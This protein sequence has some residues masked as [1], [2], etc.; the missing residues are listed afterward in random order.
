MIA[1]TK[2]GLVVKLLFQSA[3]L[4]L[5]LHTNTHHSTAD[6]NQPHCTQ[7]QG[8]SNTLVIAY[9]GKIAVRE[10]YRDNISF[11]HQ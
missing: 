5:W 11:K 2:Y 1:L 7:S 9:T 10:C 8:P 4:A 6:T 3:P